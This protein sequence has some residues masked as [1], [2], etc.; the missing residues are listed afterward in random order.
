MS[1]TITLT[2]IDSKLS[3]KSYSFDSRT[4]CWVGRQD[5]C[6]IQFP[7][8]IDYDHVSR[9]HCLLDIDPLRISV[10]D[11]NSKYGTFVDTVLIGRREQGQAAPQ[12]MNV[13]V[14]PNEQNLYSGNVIKIGNVHIQVKITGEQ[15]DYTPP[16]VAKTP[17]QIK[18]VADKAIEWLK[19]WLE[20][21]TSIKEDERSAIGGY[22]IIKQLGEGG[23][24]QVFL[25]ENALGKQIAIKV[26]LAE[27]AATPTKVKMFE[28]EIDNAK[29]LNHPNVVQVTDNGFDPVNNCLFYGM[30]YCK[31]DNLAV[32]VEKMGGILNWDLAKRLIFQI[33]DGLE[34][35]HTAEIPFVRLA[36]RS[37]GKGVGLVHRDL[38]PKNIMIANTNL[39]QVAK[40]GDFGLSKA[41]D[42]AGLSGHSMSGDGF[43]GT[44]EF[45]CR[46]QVLDFQKAQPEV[47][48]WAAAA[49]LYYMLTGKAPRD[50][51]K[52]EGWEVLLERDVILIRDRNPD[53]PALLAEVIDRALHEE[54]SLANLHYQR[55]ADFKVDLA[56]AFHSISP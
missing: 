7:E 31:G 13:A 15:P 18:V 30:E 27:V 32:F 36:D 35:T 37:F 52:G 12:N 33:L 9:I 29:V 5:S 1:A 24:G 17:S 40:I 25:A 26:M 22:K 23:Y 10:R 51:R 44:A 54:G 4:I 20:I 48:I 34:Y 39:G 19:I 14:K 11:F 50:V 3:G 6:T 41:F 2:I 21:P 42:L 43:R 8:H 56:Q 28:R 53:I 46:K 16:P 49:C 47:D 55:V 38:K 45:M